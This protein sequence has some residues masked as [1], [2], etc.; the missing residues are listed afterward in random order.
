VDGPAGA[1][2][3]GLN[4]TFTSF[5]GS[6]A[7]SPSVAGRDGDISPEASGRFEPI[8]QIMTWLRGQTWAVVS[9]SLRQPQDAL[10]WHCFKY[11]L[12]PCTSIV[13]L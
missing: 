4:S 7:G 13:C 5:N 11:M 3:R 1:A 12:H 9:A 2:E 10:W 8:L 6:R